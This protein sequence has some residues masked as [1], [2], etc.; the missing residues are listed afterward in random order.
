MKSIELSKS[1]W[2][3]VKLGYGLAFAFVIGLTI[4]FALLQMEWI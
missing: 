1:E 3:R 4:H 2:F